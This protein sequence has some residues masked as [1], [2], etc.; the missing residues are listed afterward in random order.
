MASAHDT[1]AEATAA[2]QVNLGSLAGSLRTKGL[3]VGLFALA[4]LAGWGFAAGDGFQQFS[5][6]YLVGVCFSLTISLGALFFVLIHH[7]VKARWSTVVRR[8]AELLTTAFPLLGVLLIG[9]LALP[10]VLG[11]DGLYEWVNEDVRHNDHLVHAKGA[12]FSPVFFLIRIVIY[13]GVWYLLSRYFLSKSVQ[14]DQTGDKDISERLRVMSAPALLGFAFSTAFAGFDLLMSLEPRWFSTMFPV[15]FFGGAALAIYS[16]LALVVMYLQGKG[17]LTK[18]V[19]AEHY[20]D[21]G[22]FMFGFIFFWGYIAFSQFMLIWYADL[23]EETMWFHT[24]FEH[25]WGWISAALLFVHFV[26]PF[27]G[28]MSRHPKRRKVTL[29]LLAVWCLLAH[30]LDLFWL[31]FPKFDDG[32]FHASTMVMSLL[33]IVAVAGLTVFSVANKAAKTPLLP[34][35]DPNLRSSLQFENI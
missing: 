25:G 27:L 30:A 28:L 29:A 19:N 22:K 21:L 15:Y 18:S 31:V 14:Q 2:D 5:F 1:T 32:H 10:A 4:L 16:T 7:L 35:K 26:L 12:W 11:Y 33:A 20:H 34:V 6:A 23:P 8:V 17:K 13:V 24:R 9:G 3:V